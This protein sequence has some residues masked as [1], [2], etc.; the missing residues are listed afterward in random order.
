MTDDEPKP[1]HKQKLAAKKD[2]RA[3]WFVA[4][5]VVGAVLGTAIGGILSAFY[6][7]CMIP[8]GS[9]WPTLT[10]GTRVFANRRMKT[11]ER[12]AVVVFKYPE[13]REQSFAKR[14]VGLPGDVIRS[15]DDGLTIN[16]WKVPRCV[17]GKT[18]YDDPASE[19]Q[20]HE[21]NVVVEWLG[22]AVYL[23]FE[24]EHAPSLG[25]STRFVVAAGEY[26]VVGDNRRNSHDSRMWNG[27]QGRG[28]PLADTIGRVGG[29]EKPELPANARD[30]DKLAAALADCLGKKPESTTPPSPSPK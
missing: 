9:M 5:L 10:A 12:G 15:T 6:A 16:D 27:G 26:F 1:T 7:A 4:I 3:R 25:A 2:P 28:V 20:N 22:D 21:G 30:R 18:G 11:P 24:D 13:R 14:I 19:G 23:V 29:S 17:V 8:A